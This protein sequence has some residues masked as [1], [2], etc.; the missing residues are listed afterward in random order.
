MVTKILLLK[1]LLFFGCEVD[2]VAM[3]KEGTKV[4]ESLDSTLNMDLMSTNLT[5]R[6]KAGSLSTKLPKR[7][8]GGVGDDA[9][10]ELEYA[11]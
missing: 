9:Y 7:N 2:N 6:S 5:W 11:F 3:V 10:G 1:T 8:L 4:V